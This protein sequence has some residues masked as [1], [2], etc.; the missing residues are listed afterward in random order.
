MDK[1]L[2]LDELER[3]AKRATQ[4]RR[5]RVG[6]KVYARGHGVPLLTVNDLGPSLGQQDEDATYIATFDPPTILTLIAAARPAVVSDEVVER[7]CRAHDDED[8]AMMGEPS[9]W[10]IRDRG[11]FD[12]SDAEW[13]T[14]RSE[15]LTAM[16]AALAL[17]P[18]GVVP[19]GYVLVPREP[20]EAMQ[21]AGQAAADDMLWRW[22]GLGERP[23]GTGLD[24]MTAC[25]SD[26]YRA[27]LSASP[28]DVSP[29][30]KDP[31]HGR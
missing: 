23:D 20:T 9:L 28:K 3:V 19:D 27:M 5:Y 7:M 21:K 14:Y 6:P 10:V 22:K 31:H 1:T 18:G 17:L 12:G 24:G 8:A 2:D 16:R 25:V 26:A 13:E 11:D 30:Q 4:A 15:R 29:T